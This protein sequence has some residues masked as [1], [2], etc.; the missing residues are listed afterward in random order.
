M[1]ER[2]KIKRNGNKAVKPSKK[3]TKKAKDIKP[4]KS[5]DE[6]L[7]SK[8]KSLN[9]D[10]DDNASR[11]LERLTWVAAA[12]VVLG[13]AILAYSSGFENEAENKPLSTSQNT[14]AIS[15]PNIGGPFTL[16][17]QNGK[18]TTDLDFKGRYMLVYFGYTYCPDICPNSLTTMS[19]ALDILGEDANNVTPILISFD[20]ARDT[21]EYLKE[22]AS[23]F[24]PRLKALTGTP[25][26]IASVTKAY[27]VYY[28]KVIKEDAEPEDYLMNHSSAT[29]LMGPNG[30]FLLHF[31][32]GTDAEIMARRIREKLY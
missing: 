5:R 6:E 16:I 28:A 31:S 27:R 21:P 2:Q 8:P 7:M 15:K 32:H 25:E 17:D 1:S 23:Y 24:H 9:G 30:A 22:Y 26:Q 12:L 10:K 19:D 18:P 11:G 29:Y 14:I 4:L 13:L 20:P 3:K